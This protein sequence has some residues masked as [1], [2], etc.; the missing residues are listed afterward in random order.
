MGQG[1]REQACGV[2]RLHQVVADG[3]KE[4]G[5]GLVGRLGGALGFGQGDVELRQL[6]GA[7]RHPAFQAFVGFGQR[8]FGLAERGDVG[9]THD[10]STAWHGVADQLDHA[11]VREQSFGGVGAALAHPVQTA[12]DVHFRFTGAAKPTLGVIADDVGNRP[13]DTD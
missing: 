3:C 8:L 6:V 2:Q 11:P 1:G 10:K 12:R 7:L 13:A 5:F 9:E 4:S